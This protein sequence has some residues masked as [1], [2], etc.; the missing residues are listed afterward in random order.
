MCLRP[1]Y[2]KSVIRPPNPKQ[3]KAISN[4]R[5]A[6]TTRG[7]KQ[8]GI[9]VS[10]RQNV[11]AD[12]CGEPAWVKKEKV[13][14]IAGFFIRKWQIKSLVVVVQ[15]AGTFSVRRPNVVQSLTGNAEFRPMLI[16]GGSQLTGDS[17]WRRFREFDVMTQIG[18]SPNFLK[19]DGGKSVLL[20]VFKKQIRIQLAVPNCARLYTLSRNVHRGGNQ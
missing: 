6:V 4:S 13:I 2:Y 20:H 14:R 18:D 16:Y 15:D 10:S 7:D 17:I 3:K 19:H 5:D 9:R 11:V 12:E 8:S 1:P